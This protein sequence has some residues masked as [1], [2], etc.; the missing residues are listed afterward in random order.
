MAVDPESMLSLTAR[1]NLGWS[2]MYVFWMEM[3]SYKITLS[4]ISRSLKNSIQT[5][6]DTVLAYDQVNVFF[7]LYSI[8]MP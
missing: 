3:W 8:K 7:N 1:K 2:E 4:G 5:T 6:T